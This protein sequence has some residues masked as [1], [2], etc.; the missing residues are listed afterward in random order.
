MIVDE[1]ER[2]RSGPE[3]QIDQS[4]GRTVGPSFVRMRVA[5]GAA[6]ACL[7]ASRAPSPLAPEPTAGNFLLPAN[8]LYPVGASI[9]D[10]RTDLGV[11]P[12]EDVVREVA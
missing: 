8:I 10:V 9:Y 3:L 5:S 12:K 2:A 4:I 11:S 7:L 1:A 6:V